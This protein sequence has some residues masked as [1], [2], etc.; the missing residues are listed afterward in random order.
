MFIIKGIRNDPRELQTGGALRWS[1][2]NA[3]R[4]RAGLISLVPWWEP[5]AVGVGGGCEPVG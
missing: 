4:K 5:P 1:W 2:L 3:W